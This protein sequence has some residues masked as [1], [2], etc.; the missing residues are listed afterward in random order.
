MSDFLQNGEIATLHRLKN[1]SFR[2]L[3]NELKEAT[4][5]HRI[6]LVLPYIPV[7]LKGRGVPKIIEE[8]RHVDYVKNIIVPVGRRHGVVRIPFFTRVISP[9]FSPMGHGNTR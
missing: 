5:L 6:S 4:R 8:L 3:E 1:R 2:E 7:E 9:V